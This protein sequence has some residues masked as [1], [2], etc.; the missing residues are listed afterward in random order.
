VEVTDVKVTIMWTPPD[1][2]VTGYRVDV[3]PVNLPGEHG[4]RL[5][6]SRNTFAEVTG[7]SPGV[8]YY[9]KVFAVNH[10]R[11]SKPLT[12]QQTTSMS[13]SFLSVLLPPS[14]NSP[15]SSHL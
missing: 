13:Y 8:T 14:P 2:A 5:P 12:A 7:L 6:I 3:I 15:L 10:G 11:E 9:F 1:S 4:Q